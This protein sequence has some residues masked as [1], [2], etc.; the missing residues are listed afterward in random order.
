MTDR[1]GYDKHDPAGRGAGNSR[2]GT[3]SKMVLTEV[4]P[5][6]ITVPRDPTTFRPGSH[7]GAGVPSLDARGPCVQFRTP[8]IGDS[9]ERA[10][11]HESHARPVG[12]RG[13][14]GRWSVHS[15]TIDA[16]PSMR[17]SRPPPWGT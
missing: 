3:R 8:G 13:Y 7:P 14:S 16:V 2:N 6:E 17:K 12:V 10:C 5:V 1:L 15:A 4:G 9:H 11:S